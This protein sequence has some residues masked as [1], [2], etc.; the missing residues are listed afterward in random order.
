MYKFT[1][2]CMTGIESIDK[3]H[4]QL[5]KIINEAQALLEEQA[6][7]VKT[8]KSIVAHLVDYAAEHF[9]HEES[10]MES[11][12][13]PELMR[14][15]KE[16][17]DFA[18]KVKSV[19]FDN[20]TDEESRKELAEL[21]KFLAK[22]LYHH[23][24]GS[25]I[26]IG[27]LEPVV[28]KT[29]DS[30]KAENVSTAKKGMFEFTDEYK[31]DIDFV[32]AEHKKLFEII[33]RT[34]EVINDYYLHDKYDHIVSIINELKDYIK[35]YPYSMKYNVEDA[36]V[37]EIVSNVIDDW[38]MQYRNLSNFVHGTNSKFFQSAEY[39]DEFKFVKKDVNF[40]T[41]QVDILSS[42]VN[43]LLIIF[44]FQEYI[45]FDE[46]TEKSLIRSAISNDLGYKKKVV[47]VLEEI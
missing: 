27:K 4:E 8:V 11:I 16:H 41:K 31:T 2:D 44:Y 5:F 43:T 20:M 37:Q 32:D 25:D 10:Y 29:Q 47:E 24:L 30:K 1:K 38:T 18:N 34:Y 42:I 9:A 23:I 36:K 21:V 39:I 6:V 12:N 7:D 14:Q 35:N 3:E 33:E 13:D 17:T 28:H 22:W 19:D 45:K 40:L 46:N 15:K 26:M